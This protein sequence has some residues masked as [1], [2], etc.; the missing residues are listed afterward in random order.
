MIFDEYNM[1]RYILKKPHKNDVFLKLNN[2]KNRIQLQFD[3]FQSSFWLK[4]S[5]QII[6]ETIPSN[7]LTIRLIG[8]FLLKK[9]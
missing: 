1:T 4:I 9:Y 7:K 2:A 3:I 8:A 5:L 6:Q